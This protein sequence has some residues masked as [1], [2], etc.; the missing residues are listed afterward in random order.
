MDLGT[1]R[2]G[3][4]PLSYELITK[5][6]AQNQDNTRIIGRAAVH[7]DDPYVDSDTRAFLEKSGATVEEKA[8]PEGYPYLLVT[9][10]RESVLRG[11]LESFNVP[12]ISIWDL[13]SQSWEDYEWDPYKVQK[14]KIVVEAE[15]RL[16]EFESGKRV[17]K[18]QQIADLVIVAGYSNY[19]DGLRFKEWRDRVV[20][21]V[22][23]EGRPFLRSTWKLLQ[24]HANGQQQTH[25]VADIRALNKLDRISRHVETKFRSYLA[26]NFEEA[27]SE[28]DRK[29]GKKINTDNARELSR[30]YALSKDTRSLFAQAT[31]LPATW[32][33]DK[34]FKMRLQEE[35]KA[36]EEARVLFTAG[37]PGAGKSSALESSAQELI[38]KSQLILDSALSNAEIAILRI[39]EVLAAGKTVT[40]AAVY[41]DPV[42]AWRNGVLTRAMEEGRTVTVDDH[43]RIHSRMRDALEGIAK[44]H[45]DD[46]RVEIGFVDNSHGKGNA[47]G[48]RNISIFQRVENVE[49]LRERLIQETEEAYKNGDIERNIYL[50]SIGG[51][52][53]EEDS[54]TARRDRLNALRGRVTSGHTEEIGRGERD[55]R[56]I[57]DQP[58]R[59][60]SQ[61]AQLSE[62]DQQISPSISSV[63]AS[64]GIVGETEES[65]SRSLTGGLVGSD[66]EQIPDTTIATAHHLTEVATTY[67]TNIEKADYHGDQ[68]ASQHLAGNSSVN[69]NTEKVQESALDRLEPGAPEQADFITNTGV[70]GGLTAGTPLPIGTGE[71]HDPSWSYADDHAQWPEVE[72][73]DSEEI[74]EDYFSF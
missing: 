59:G 39:D 64:P 13:G 51:T 50:G 53:S 24:D 20:E 49:A 71:N 11:C 37:G 67:T 74:S 60:S 36:G 34:L 31:Y 48:G 30:D 70:A 32:F 3:G 63:T 1:L 2:Q 61:E 55:R 62:I 8:D 66:M 26:N 6:M 28:Y 54:P 25:T 57:R 22:G 18:G 29:F 7:F 72:V 69:R 35:P 27:V 21:N 40:I 47:V 15:A 45:K 14:P 23:D 73:T 56:T 41:R 46:P 38:Q 65:L 42:D 12:R 4:R 16:V 9:N 10:V 52:E 43:I 58:E 44:Y 33:A 68:G 17:S 5:L 19:G